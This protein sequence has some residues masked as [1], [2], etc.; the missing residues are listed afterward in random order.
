MTHSTYQSAEKLSSLIIE[1]S[2]HYTDA[3]TFG[4]RSMHVAVP[5][6]TGSVSTLN[7][8]QDYAVTLFDVALRQPIRLRLDQQLPPLIEVGFML[9]GYVNMRVE[10]CRREYDSLSGQSYA[11]VFG[12]DI[13]TESIFPANQQVRMLELRLTPEKFDD[14]CCA[15]GLPAPRNMQKSLSKISNSP[16]KCTSVASKT[17]KQLA[18]QILA[19]HADATAQQFLLES[20][21]HDL[22]FQYLSFAH[23]GSLPTYATL[24]PRDI[25]RVREA[26]YILGSRLENPPSLSELARLVNLNDFKL[27]LGFRQAFGTTAFRYLKQ[28]RL[29]KARQLLCECQDSITDVALAVGYRNV[30][31]FGIAFKQKYGVSPRRFRTTKKSVFR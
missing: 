20:L 1:E 7:L 22:L 31:D 19:L 25:E 4:N 15:I 13:I 28:L 21:S 2:Q 6:A 30:G 3:Y 11:S 10:G 9:S 17:M 24:T 12:G 26:R 8:S 16:Y 14:K 23:N 5:A 18:W 29:Q 27:K